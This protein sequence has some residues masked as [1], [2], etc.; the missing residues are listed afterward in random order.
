MVYD[1]VGQ[2]RALISKIKAIRQ[3]WG[4]QLRFDIS[5]VIF[6]HIGNSLI[7]PCLSISKV[8]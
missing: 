5:S 3:I 4:Y 2:F 6:S 7:N 1:R 8:A